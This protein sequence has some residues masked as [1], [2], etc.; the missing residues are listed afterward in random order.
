VIPRR[1]PPRGR[2]FEVS[3]GEIAGL[4]R[5]YAAFP[6]VYAGKQQ[7]KNPN[8]NPVERASA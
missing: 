2:V 4:T 6:G 8:E 1:R 7:K 5:E 3:T